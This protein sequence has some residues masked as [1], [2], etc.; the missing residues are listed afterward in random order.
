MK[1]LMVCRRYSGIRADVWMPSGTPAVVKLI[2]ELEARGHETTVLFLGKSAAT[3]TDTVTNYGCFRHTAFFHIG[4]RGISWL[5]RIFSDVLND[6]R[7]FVKIVPYLFRHTDI[8]YFDRAH[9]GFAALASI[10]HRRVV[11]RCLGVMSFVI[12]KDAGK[13]LGGF[14][15]ALARWLVRFPIALMVCTNDGSPW[16]RL[17][18][19]GTWR[20]ML[21]ITNGVDWPADPEANP[22]RAAHVRPMIGFVGRATVAKGVDLFVEVCG[23]LAARQVA[24]R[25]VVIGEGQDLQ[26]AQARAQ[27]LG[28]GMIEFTGSVPHSKIGTVFQSIDIYLSPARNGAFSN[29][30]IEAIAAGCCVIALSPDRRTMVDATTERFLPKEAVFWADRFDPIRSCASIVADLT[31]SPSRLRERQARVGEFA[32]AQFRP[33]S[34]RIGQEAE[35]LETLARRGDMPSAFLPGDEPACAAFG[36]APK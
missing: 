24:F 25:A 27:E 35:M 34:E 28:L 32:R 13:R 20:R 11:W 4:W 5:P 16:M 15:L 2:E 26:A 12:A 10:V 31:A 23:E 33:W 19:P 8:L 29:T 21:L 22:A 6:A 36:A 18:T 14:Y 3:R 9:L 30:T 1:V 7:Q 17:F